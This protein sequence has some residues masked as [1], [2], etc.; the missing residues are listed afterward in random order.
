MNDFSSDYS[1]E[2]NDDTSV[3]SPLSEEEISENFYVHPLQD[4]NLGTDVA[5][6]YLI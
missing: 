6:R 5:D 1:L 3:T 2:D 4:Q